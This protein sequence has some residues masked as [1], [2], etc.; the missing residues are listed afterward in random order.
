MAFSSTIAK[1]DGRLTYTP[2]GRV[3]LESIEAFTTSVVAA[4]REAKADGVVL[5]VDLSQLAFMISRGLRALTLAQREGAT[6]KLARPNEDMTDI[7]QISRYDKL[8]EIEA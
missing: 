7:L 2:T 8:F 4:A 3:D 6:V 5:V 1:S